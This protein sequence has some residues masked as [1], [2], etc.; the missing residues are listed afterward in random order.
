VNRRGI[1]LYSGGLDSILAGK[2]LL[3]QG[4]D[5]VGYH[6]ILPFAP[7]DA[8]PETM[9][10]SIMARRIGLP[11]KHI[12]C[13]RDYMEM[14]KDPPH[15]HGKNINPCIDCKLHFLRTAGLAMESEGAAF[16]ATGEVV[17]QRPMSQMRHMMNHIEKESGLKGRLLRPLCAKR[18]KPTEAEIA[19][20]V[21]RERLLSLSGRN[22][23]PQFELAARYGITDYASP[24]GGCLFTDPKIA[25]RVRDL[26]DH[27]PN[28][29]MA[30]VYLLTKGRHFR[31][32]GNVKFIISRNEG[33]NLELVKY[34]DGADLFLE[35][36]FRGPAAYVLGR[37]DD[38]VPVMVAAAISRYG[39]PGDGGRLIRLYSRGRELAPLEA[40]G[41]ADDGDLEKM[42][43]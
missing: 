40:P 19:G 18:L 2:L 33:E 14:V 5:V 10:P 42:R 37:V 21:D 12:R 4:L 8:D 1:L 28:Y 43:I 3:E 6:F 15:G 36:G 26:L 25:E 16:V 30:D 17:G 31:M 24:A 39:R 32:D 23:K 9:K 13:G 7:P 35:P 38:T 22:R 20:I 27:H 34:R 41:P 29:T 11:L